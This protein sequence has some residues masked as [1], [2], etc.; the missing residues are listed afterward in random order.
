MKA[1]NIY[2]RITSYLVL[3]IIICTNILYFYTDMLETVD[4]L[5]NIYKLLII[6]FGFLGGKNVALNLNE[7]KK[8]PLSKKIPLFMLC[9]FTLLSIISF[10]YFSGTFLERYL[11]SNIVFAIAIIFFL[12]LDFQIRKEAR[13]YEGKNPIKREKMFASFFKFLKNPFAFFSNRLKKNIDQHSG[14]S[15]NNKKSGIENFFKIP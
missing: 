10:F 3:L 14:D 6:S 13:S 2:E 4:G 5:M 12:I 7:V 9:F 1:F 8:W 11:M 15:G